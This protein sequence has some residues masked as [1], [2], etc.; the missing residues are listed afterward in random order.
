LTRSVTKTTGALLLL[1]LLCA[2]AGCSPNDNLGGLVP[3]CI[4]FTPATTPTAGEVVAV[5][6]DLSDCDTAVIELAVSGVDNL[7]GISFEMDY[8]SGIS[9]VFPFVDVSTSVL[10]DQAKLIFF[11]DE[12][13]LGHIE[14]GVSRNNLYF[15]QG[16]PMADLDTNPVVLR[17]GF[18]RFATGGSGDAEFTMG[19]TSLSFRQAGQ[20][21]TFDDTIP[22]SGGSLFIQ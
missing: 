22:F 5:S 11:L 3:T 15:D 20:E 13:P 1:A 10:G 19:T 9:Q 2:A 7:W 8:P 16:L 4:S 18:Q 14:V 21:P 6:S 12:D 17:L